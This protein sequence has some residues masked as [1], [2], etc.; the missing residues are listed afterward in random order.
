VSVANAGTARRIGPALRR[1]TARH[2]GCGRGWRCRA[3]IDAKDERA[4]AWYE[5]FGALRL[6]DDPLRLML[7]LATIADTV[8]IRAKS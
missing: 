4:A 8:P 5:R 7:P 3:A 2:R 6:M 1:W